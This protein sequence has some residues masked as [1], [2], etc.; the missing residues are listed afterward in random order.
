MAK[1]EAT[2]DIGGRPVTQCFENAL[3][4]LHAKLVKQIVSADDPRLDSGRLVLPKQRHDRLRQAL[5]VDNSDRCP[6]AGTWNWPSL[7]PPPHNDDEIVF[8]EDR[9]AIVARGADS[10]GQRSESVTIVRTFS[11]LLMPCLG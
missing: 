4:L 5:I 3:R 11:P 10:L 7:P 2:F 1:R 8:A 9:A 6:H